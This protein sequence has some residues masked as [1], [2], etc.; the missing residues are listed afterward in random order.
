[1]RA[2]CYSAANVAQ[3]AQARE[4]LQKFSESKLQSIAR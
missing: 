3:A 1:M 2:V 4:D